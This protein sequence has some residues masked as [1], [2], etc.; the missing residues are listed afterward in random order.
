MMI[1]LP[2][3]ILVL[4]LTV[5]QAAPPAPPGGADA[6]AQA[7]LLLRE[8]T[9]LFDRGEHGAALEKFEEAYAV[10]PS[11][12]IW[13]DVGVADRVLARNAEAMEAF[14]RFLDEAP[15]APTASRHEAQQA[16]AELTPL[17]GR[18]NIECALA[19]TYVSVDGRPAGVTPLA[20]AVWAAPGRHQIAGRHDGMVPDIQEVTVAAGAAHTLTLVLRPLAPP[21]APVTAAPSLALPPPAPSAITSPGWSAAPATDRPITRQWWFWTAVGAVVAAGVVGVVL[22]TRG[23]ATNVPRTT[24]GSQGFP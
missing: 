11:P 6:K 17:L 8:G 16:I 4:A 5:A 14:G 2:S 9:A 3:S 23:D 20:R 18:L 19:G 15:D 7:T 10:Y 22:A 1:T 12:K 13:F 24:L 21:P